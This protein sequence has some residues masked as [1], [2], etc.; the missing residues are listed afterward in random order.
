V[1]PEVWRN[2][3]TS[4]YTSGDTNAD[5]FVDLVQVL[6]AFSP[7]GK[8]EVRV[9][10]GKSNFQQWQGGW[11][12]PE[13]WHNGDSVEYGMAD[14][15]N[16]GKLDLYQMLHQFTRSGRVEVK[17]LDG[18]QGFRNWI[19]GWTTPEGWHSGNDVHI[20]VPFEG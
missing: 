16:D 18:A 1:T 5:G 4:S 8:T 2:G 17:I 7:S 15:N 10:D 6:H 3:K 9:L 19:G 13:G 14:Y 12:T 11:V 20:S